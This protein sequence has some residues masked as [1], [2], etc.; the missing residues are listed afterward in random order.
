[1][2]AAWKKPVKV[3]LV[4]GPRD[5]EIV[6]VEHQLVFVTCEDRNGAYHRNGNSN[7]GQLRTFHYLRRE[8]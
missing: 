3:R 6:E 5:E 2:T 1:M 7:L 4:G 8:P